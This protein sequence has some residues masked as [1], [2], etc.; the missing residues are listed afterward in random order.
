MLL[1]ELK[2]VHP[3][4]SLSFLSPEIGDEAP[5]ILKETISF[6]LV[7][8]ERVNPSSWALLLG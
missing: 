7:R 4:L 8:E 2:E 3:L 6:L 1:Y 5:Q